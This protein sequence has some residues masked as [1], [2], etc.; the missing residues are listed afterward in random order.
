MTNVSGVSF[1]ATNNT[2]GAEVLSAALAKRQQQVEGQAAIA[3]IEA[4]AQTMQ[5]LASPSMPTATLGN[6]INTYV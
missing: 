1:S 6:N 2:A 3:L 5:S 4:T